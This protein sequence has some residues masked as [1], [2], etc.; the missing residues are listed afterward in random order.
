MT[1]KEK[2][3]FW[4]KKIKETTKNDDWK[5]KSYFIFKTVN[6]FFFSAHFYGHGKLNEIAGWLDYKPINID[7]VFWDIIHEQPNKKMPLSFRGEAAFCVRR[8]TYFEFNIHIN[9]PLNPES[10]IKQLF[11]TINTKVTEKAGDIKTLN[12]FRTE[13]LKE[14][15]YNTVGII[16]SFIEEEQFEKAL[17]KIKEYRTNQFSSGFGFGDKDFYDLASEYCQKNYR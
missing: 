7:T 14:E 5:F 16:T 9:D 12:D 13:M 15:E 6:D 4:L 11:R 10:E 1:N 2:E 8:I 3:R 17:S